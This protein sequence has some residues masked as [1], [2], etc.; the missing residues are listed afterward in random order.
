MR[1]ATTGLFLAAALGLAASVA[2]GQVTDQEA[3]EASG[4]AVAPPAGE[5]PAEAA[6][7]TSEPKSLFELLDMVKQGLEVERAENRRRVERFIQRREDQKRL[8]A[9]A[10]ATLAREEGTSQQLETTYNENELALADNEERL[11]ERLGELGELFG[12]VRQV[13]TDTSGNVWD[14]LTSSQLGPRKELLDRLGRSKELPSTEDLEKLWYEL[15]REMTQQGQVVRYRAPV[16]TIEGQIEERDVIRAGPFSAISRGRYLLW[17]PSEG[18]LRELTRQP[19]AR[20]VNTVAPFEKATSGFHPL[21][22][23][24]SRGSLLSALTD[25][26]DAKERVQQGGYVGYTIIV[27]GV[28]ALL[29]GLA[30]WAAIS[31]VSRKVAVQRKSKRAN[32]GNPLGRVLSVFEENRDADPET[33]ELKLDEAVLRESSKLERFLWLVKTVSVVA[34]LLGL[35]GTVT[36][37]IKT[38]QAITLFG[39]GDPRMMASGISEAL[40]TTMLGLMTAIPLV[41]LYDTL[42]NSTRRVV[43]VLDEQSAGLIAMRSEDSNA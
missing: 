42:A 36:G 27:L 38:F 1:R 34:P 40:V 2:H 19:P 4:A 43:D 30:R 18:K 9:E 32:L 13:A 10:H 12:V 14:S 37:M 3:G 22:V 23:D 25:T 6:A 20:Y 8:L 29:L 41:L 26:P 24:P 11:K 21:A 17:E 35:L 5:A 31:V 39:A 7:A 16:L 28:F 15:Q 33:L